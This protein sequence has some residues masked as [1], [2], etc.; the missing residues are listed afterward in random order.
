MIIWG[1]RWRGRGSKEWDAQWCS[2]NDLLTLQGR[3]EV[4][5]GGR[6][7]NGEVGGKVG[8]MSSYGED[9]GK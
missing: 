7:V 5:G 3:D 9:L 2:V 4:C 6:E 1:G 8:M